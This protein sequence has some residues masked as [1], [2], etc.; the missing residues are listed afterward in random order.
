M[1]LDHIVISVSNLKRS[2]KFY[3]TFLGI[4]KVNLTEAY[5]VLG[6]TKLFLTKKYKVSARKFD[7]HNLGLNHIA[8]KV[9][10]L[11]ML[12]SL[13]Y[14]LD[15]AQIKHSSI[16]TDKYNHLNRLVWFDD[17]DGI[18]LEFYYRK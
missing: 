11:K 8:I 9:R 7:K 16:I 6:N 3:N 10:T 17:P 18:R 5:W 15:K 4:G 13:S 1:N 2:I 14:K 12:E